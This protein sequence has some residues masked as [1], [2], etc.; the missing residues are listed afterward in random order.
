MKK[1][2]IA[3]LATAVVSTACFARGNDA[4]LLTACSYTDYFHIGRDSEVPVTITSIK[5]DANIV[6]TQKDA[7]SF[8]LSDTPTCPKNGGIAT[9]RYTKDKTNYCDLAIHDAENFWGPEIKA[10][11]TG[12]LRFAGKDKDNWFGSDSYSLNFN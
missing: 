10:T 1:I 9:V 2:A 11:C 3:L 7:T 5:G 8:E 6:A 4:N 12:S